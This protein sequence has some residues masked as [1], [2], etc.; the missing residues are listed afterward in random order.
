[1]HISDAISMPVDN[2]H[3]YYFGFTGNTFGGTGNLAATDAQSSSG[4]DYTGVAGNTNNGGNPLSVS[5]ATAV[6][7]YGTAFPI[8]AASFFIASWTVA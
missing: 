5:W 8:G 3:D 1:M 4:L 6:P 2:N 7:I